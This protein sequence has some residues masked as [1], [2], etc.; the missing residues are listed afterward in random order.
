MELKVGVFQYDIVW[1]DTEANLSYLT[2]NLR[3]IDKDTDVLILPEMFHCGFTMSP[4]LNAQHEG[5][6]VLKWMQQAAGEYNLAVMGSVVV[7]SANQFYNRFYVV[8]KEDVKWYDKR[9]LFT[10]SDEHLHY[11]SGNERLIVDIKGWRFCPLICYDLRFPVWSR[12]KSKAYDV[13]VYVANWPATRNHV[14]DTLLKAR[15]IEN[16]SYVI[17]VNR[18]GTGQNLN[19]IG[20]SQVV[21]AKGQVV[22][23][24]SNKCGIFYVSLKRTELE[25]FREKF[26][27]LDDADEFELL[28]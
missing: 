13:L 26:P 17:G 28:D 21:N 15:A 1:E 6:R 14:W 10:M 18:I 8:T 9:H 22:L 12:N 20:N 3:H 25:A 19:Y 27:V 24:L 5:G 11:Q 7:E 4:A 16:Q 2:D 23:N